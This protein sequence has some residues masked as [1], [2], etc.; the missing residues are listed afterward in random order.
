MERLPPV[1][2]DL[3]Q[4]IEAILTRVGKRVV[5]C[6]PLGA[7]K[8]TVLLNAFY[9]RAL[10]DPSIELTLLTALSLARPGWKSELERRFVEPMAERVF[11]DA[12]NPA[13]LAPNLAGKLPANVKVH[14]FYV[15]PGSYLHSPSAQQSYASLNY[16]HVARAVLAR[17]ANV[18]AQ[19]VARRRG[20]EGDDYS[21]GVNPDVTVDLLPAIAAMR[22]AGQPVAFIGQVNEQM[23]FMFGASI[24]E[25]AVFDAIVDTPSG[26]HG[27]FSPPNLPISTADYLIALYASALVRDGGTLQIGIGELGDA[28]V[29]ALMLR[30][31]RN[32]LWR[33]V[34]KDIGASAR[35]GELLNGMGGQDPFELGLYANSE[36]FVD[37]FLD[38]YKAG[39]LKRRVY[40]DLAHQRRSN[41][42]LAVPPEAGAGAILHGAFLLGPQAF[43]QAL[44]DMPDAERAQFQM[45]P[46]SFTNDLAGPDWALKVAQR[47]HARFINTT[48]IATLLGAA[49]SDTLDDGRVVSGVGGQYN[50][51][52][53]AHGLPGGRSILCLRATR[54]SDGRTTSNIRFAYGQATIPRHLRDVYITEYGVA[55]LRGGSDA[56]VIA[57]MLNI[58][59][60]R[61]QPALMAEAKRA[62]K[63]PREHRIADEH[64]NNFPA[65]LEAALAP[66][67][68]SGL[69]AEL[70]FDSD[71]TADEIA[72]GRALKSLQAKSKTWRGRASLLASLLMP[73]P[74]DP[75][76]TRMLERMDLA[77]PK[78]VKEW[79]WRKL[80]GR[81]TGR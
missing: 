51:V 64:R 57:A 69:F 13:W 53:Q 77:S 3:E 30:H 20:P 56:E 27:L 62:G 14:E 21:L 71:L 19:Q 58:A 10:A 74:S 75:A 44:R 67:R 45:A 39:I 68:A 28:I 8:P 7:G 23:P 70:P 32:R 54:E 47:Q 48:M 73:M 29:Y 80:V 38:L 60:S 81:A 41:A 5:L 33:R 59:D 24:V 26:H 36:M 15:Q 76:V 49:A 2:D 61:F 35:F 78:S 52:A 31:Q 63:L 66:H 72:L 6:A 9:Q 37:G 43:Y 34:Q 12:P 40:P 25:P 11:G 50:F 65:A 46:V 16:T 1:Y 22:K 42:G 55:D 79:V 18:I 17:G 4:C